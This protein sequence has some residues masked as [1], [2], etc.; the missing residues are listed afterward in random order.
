M[1]FKRNIVSK[2]LSNGLKADFALVQVEDAFQAALYVD[3]RAI[4]G[5]PLPVPLDPCKGDVTHW[6]GNRPSVGLTTEEAQKIFREVKLENSVLE[7][8]KILQEP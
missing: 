3:G 2:I 5:P 6:M 1:I 4:P 7:H 8:R